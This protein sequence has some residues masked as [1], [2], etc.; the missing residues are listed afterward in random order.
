MPTD[1]F[2]AADATIVLATD[3]TLPGGAPAQAIIGQYELTNAVGRLTN[4]SVSVHSAVEPFY[5]V[6]RRYPAALRPGR[7]AVSGSADRALIN[8]AL[9]RLLLGDGAASPPS[10][11]SFAQPAF[12][13]LATLREPSRPDAFAKVTV[14]GVHFD[15]WSY[16]VGNDRDFVMESVTFQAMRLGYEEA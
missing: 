14:F 13:V 4:L 2:R 7:I 1:V 16:Q 9:V 3:D 5:E 8:G 6:G 10:G 11:P 12:N 15:S